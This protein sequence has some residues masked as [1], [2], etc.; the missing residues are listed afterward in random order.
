MQTGSGKFHLGFSVPLHGGRLG[1]PLTAASGALCIHRQMCNKSYTT[2]M[3]AYGVWT[4]ST[5]HTWHAG[6][7]IML[8]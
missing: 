2:V 5:K 4:V 1:V 8:L 7:L 6:W 3:P